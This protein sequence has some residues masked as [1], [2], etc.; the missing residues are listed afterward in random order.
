MKKC[1][2][3]LNK[4]IEVFRW[5]KSIFFFFR[6]NV[7]H[8]INNNFLKQNNIL[9]ELCSESGFWNYEEKNQLPKWISK[10][11]HAE[12]ELENCKVNPN[13]HFFTFGDST[14]IRL[15][16]QFFPRWKKHFSNCQKIRLKKCNRLK[17]WDIHNP[18]KNWIPPDKNSFMGP[19][20]QALT[21]PFCTD[22][23]GCH[24]NR[25]NCVS[26]KKEKSLLEYSDVEYALDVEIQLTNTN[27]T[28][29]AYVMHLKKYI[30]KHKLQNDHMLLIGNLGNHD[31]KLVEKLNRDEFLQN[32]EKFFNLIYG[33]KKIAPKLRFLWIELTTFKNSGKWPQRDNISKDWNFKIKELFRKKY[34][35]FTYVLHNYK[36][37]N[38]TWAKE[39]LFGDN[40]HLVGRNATYYKTL[41]NII[42]NYFI[43][44][45]SPVYLWKD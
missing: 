3:N 17:F 15:S 8:N 31:M 39:N 45:N 35:N 22:C 41:T 43:C 25:L 23:D 42:F 12:K 7:T 34:S 36:L 20:R 27:S 37:S 1:L 19:T 28:Q 2:K 44:Q 21:Q 29:E 5:A 16:H 30:E 33:L 11:C 40:I 10:N 24:N 9:A 38:S 6:I 14:M 32:F 4:K 13:L 26:S 18:V